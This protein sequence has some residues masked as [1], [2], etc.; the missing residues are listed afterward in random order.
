MTVRIAIPEPSSDIE[1]NSRSLPVYVEALEA[2]GASAVVVGLNDPQHQVASLLDSV[3]AILLPGSRYD[4][5]PARYGETRIPE[6]GESD[7]GRTAIDELL[8]NHAFNFKKPVL[9]ICHGAQTLNVWRN[10]SLFQDLDQA[11]KTKVNHRPG[12]TVVEAHPVEI[13]EA[14]RLAA[15]LPPGS[16]RETQVNS[17][18]H[19]AIRIP[20]DNLRITA[21][22]PVDGVVEA[23]ELDSADHF[24]LAVQWH[25][26][27]TI[28]ESAV[29]RA[30][31]KA[32]VEQAAAWKPA[33]AKD[34]VSL[35]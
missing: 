34:P 17:S 15:M 32:L 27:R 22:S 1:Y 5:D 13:A 12:R 10:G 30:I 26:E 18:H 7:A 25:P 6:C 4:V 33:G 20:G 29:S 3:E 2:A 21:V 8:L 11:L 16:T 19:Q 24:V 28:A 31:F 14:S 23:V 9:G 35:K